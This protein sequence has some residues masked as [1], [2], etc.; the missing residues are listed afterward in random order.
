MPSDPL[1]VIARLAH[2]LNDLQIQYVVGGSMASS[3]YGIPR[4]TQDVDLMANVKLDHVERLTAALEPE[5]YVAS[6]LIVDA[7][8]QQTSFNVVHLQTM[9]KADVFVAADNEWSREEM[10][11][12][13]TEVVLPEE[14][15]AIRFSS[16][17]DTILHKLLWYRIG[18]HE[19]DKQWNDILGI[20]RIQG[21][22][23]D[24]AYLERWAGSLKIDDLLG[25]ART[26]G[27][28]E[29]G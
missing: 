14:A 10:S 4:A 27:T 5:F 17:E 16:P 18:G 1:I 13:R 7:V 3:V 11:R 22:S 20:L 8:H 24:F 23:L 15:L 29:Q 25:R 28:S 6:E 19:S 12:A 26:E 21:N 2:I 9:F